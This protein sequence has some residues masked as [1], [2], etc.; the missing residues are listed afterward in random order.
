M[1]DSYSNSNITDK[2]SNYEWNNLE[3]HTQYNS[4][5]KFTAFLLDNLQIWDN[6]NFE[7]CNNQNCSISK[8]IHPI[9]K[10]LYANIL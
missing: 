7:Q 5:L 3:T 10:K 8:N 4:K 1:Y 2:W 6:D 9:N